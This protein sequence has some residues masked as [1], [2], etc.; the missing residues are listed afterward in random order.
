M[1]VRRT[2]LGAGLAAPALAA[3]ASMPPGNSMAP[4]PPDPHSHAKPGEARVT[5]VSLDLTADFARKVL[6]GTA[7][8]TIAARPDAREIVLDV[9]GLNIGSVRT[10]LGD[11]TFAIGERRPELGAPMSL[12]LIHI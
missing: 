5:H 6:A 12:S 7:T 4:L 9:D 3:C 1:L 10:N 11:T 2:F 8:L